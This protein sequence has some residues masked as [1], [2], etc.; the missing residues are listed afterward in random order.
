MPIFQLSE[1]IV[2]P[3]PSLANEDG[4]LAIGGDLSVERLI[5]AYYNGIF[6]W[7]NEGEPIMWWSPNPRCV[8]FPEKFKIPKSLETFLKKHSFT[9]SFDTRFDEVIYHCATITRKGQEGKTWI[10][11]QVQEA[12]ITLFRLGIAHSVEVY[13]KSE[14]VGGLYGIAIGK[15]F[16]GESM[17]HKVSNASKIALVALV[18][19]L[20][21]WKFEIIDNQQTSE[22]LLSFGAEEITRDYFLEV[23]KKAVNKKPLFGKWKSTSSTI[24]EYR[25]K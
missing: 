4:L 10:T 16:F 21:K 13:D 20:Q 19:Q 25:K 3:H 18:T 2:F 5:L 1:D 9:I 17:F 6:P 12:Y 22:L 8:L 11:A 14:L 15:A 23:L 7:Y 24:D